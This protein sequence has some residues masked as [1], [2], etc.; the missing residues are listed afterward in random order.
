M[1]K[2]GRIDYVIGY[3]H[4]LVAVIRRF[5]EVFHEYYFKRCFC[6]QNSFIRRFYVTFIHDFCFH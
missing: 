1:G 3:F 2:S 5:R 4:I 6:A